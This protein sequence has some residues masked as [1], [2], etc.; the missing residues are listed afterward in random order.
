MA[1]E[2]ALDKPVTDVLKKGGKSAEMLKAL[3]A[4]PSYVS[5][6]PGGYFPTSRANEGGILSDLDKAFD[7][8]LQRAKLVDD[9]EKQAALATLFN[10][11]AKDFYTKQAGSIED[12]LR[13][14][15]LAGALKFERS[16]PMGDAFPQV[17]LK[18]AAQGDLE[19]LRL[20][21]KN[22]DE[23]IGIKSVVPRRT[24][25]PAVEGVVESQIMANIR[26]N[27]D[28][29]PDAQLVAYSGRKPGTNLDKIPDAQLV[30]YSG[31]KPGQGPTAVADLA[32]QIRQKVKDNPALFSTIAVADLATQIRQKVKDNPTLFSTILEPRIAETLF[33][34]SQNSTDVDMARYPNIYGTKAVESM[35][36]DPSVPAPASYDSPM[37]PKYFLPDL[38]MAIEKGQPIQDL[39]S[40]SVKLLGMT[41]EKMFDQARQM[42]AQDLNR[43]GF[44]D[45]LKKAYVGTQQADAFEAALPKIRKLI[46]AGKPPPAD[47]MTYGIKDFLPTANDFRWVKVVKPEAVQAIAEGMN[48]SVA[49]YATS[50][51]YG[52]LRKGRAALD[53]GEAEVY[54]LYDKNNVPHVTIEYLTN[55]EGVP[56]G[57][58]NTIAQL[59]GNGPLS[60]NAL[61]K[62]YAPQIVDFMNNV[63]PSSIPTDIK[64]LLEDTDQKKALNEEVLSSVYFGV[65]MQ[66]L[67]AV[68]NNV[69]AVGLLRRLFP[70]VAPR[71]P[72]RRPFI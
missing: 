60:V 18:G 40:S 29:I 57:M 66:A 10:Q 53:S 34:R 11:K 41:P 4:P 55:K 21:E 22:Y 13:K 19:S 30:T 38:E 37:P 63:R 47:I 39:A 23:M 32:T 24:G 42:S 5:R 56:D 36:A 71:P 35:V 26:D 46:Q 48:N 52:S 2:K 28:K 61:P 12:P 45:F 69:P 62:D 25:T 27:L 16:T 49:R 44:A 20:L 58:K 7:P 14:D 65:P 15:I 67:E 8:I 70:G 6:A 68:D 51:T 72:R 50:K 33:H 31:L 1:A 54:A 64:R 59:T 3:S 9:P 43:M 17:L